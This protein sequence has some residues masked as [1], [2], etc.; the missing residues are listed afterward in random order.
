MSYQ[1]IT[2]RFNGNIIATNET[3]SHENQNFKGANFKII[4]PISE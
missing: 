1:I 4:I 3:Y 2:N